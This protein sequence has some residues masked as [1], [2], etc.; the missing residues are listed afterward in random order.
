MAPAVRPQGVERDIVHLELVVGVGQDA[1]DT[2]QES[3]GP[4]VV[5][6]EV[7]APLIVVV[8]VEIVPDHGLPPDHLAQLADGLAGDLVRHH[9]TARPHH[10]DACVQFVPDHG[11]VLA[12][13]HLGARVRVAVLGGAE[14]EDAGLPRLQVHL[15]RQVRLR[16]GGGGELLAVLLAQGVLDVVE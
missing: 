10:A 16:L 1:G 11:E 13:L 9:P 2:G 6:A 3:H 4:P 8:C 12:L 14:E 5:R 7:Q 15:V